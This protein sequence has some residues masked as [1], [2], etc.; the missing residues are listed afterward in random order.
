MYSKGSITTNSLNNLIRSRIIT[1]SQVY[2][3]GE[4]ELIVLPVNI[5]KNAN[6]TAALIVLPKLANRRNKK[7]SKSH[8]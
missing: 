5:K 4:K 2:V 3:S 1:Q 7:T 8:F 6:R